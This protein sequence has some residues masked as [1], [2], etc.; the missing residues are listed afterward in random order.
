MILVTRLFSSIALTLGLHPQHINHPDE[1]LNTNGRR[2]STSSRECL[3]RMLFHDLIVHGPLPLS[4]FGKKMA[5][6]VSVSITGKLMRLPERM[7]TL[8]HGLMTHLILWL[9]RHGLQHSISW[10]GTGRLTLLRVTG[11]K[12]HLQH[13]KGCSTSMSCHLA[14]VMRQPPFNVWWTWYLQD[15]FGMCVSCISMM[16]SLWGVTFNLTWITLVWYWSDCVK[17]VWK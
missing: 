11:T 3:R 13:G 15:C 17:L 14:F 12:R 9:G 10:A 16:S 5:P 7:R 4:W 6:C 8:F 1:S 2:L